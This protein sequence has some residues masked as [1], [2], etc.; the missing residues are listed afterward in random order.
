MS[1]RGEFL[2]A[3]FKILERHGVGY[4]VLRNYENLYEDESSDVD[5]AVQPEDV[6][7]LEV[8]L[9]EAGDASGHRL[10][11]RARFINYSHVYWNSDGGF[12]RVDFDT[13]FRWRIFPVLTAKSVITLRRREGEFYVPHPRHESVILLLAATERA[14]LSER[15]RAKL[16]RLYD[17]L[18]SPEELTRTFCSAFGLAG[19]DLALCQEEAANPVREVQNEIVSGSGSAL[20]RRGRTSL[21]RDSFR[22]RPS[23]RLLWKYLRGDVRRLWERMKSPVGLS[24]LYASAAPNQKGFE[25]FLEGT[26]VLFPPSKRVQ[27]CGARGKAL[28]RLRVLFKGG[29]FVRTVRVEK[30]TDLKNAVCARARFLFPSRELIWVQASN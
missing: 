20:W 24:I 9:A 19:S 25:E 10:V 14:E 7:G 21:V 26:E 17:Q 12:L 3:L 13:E 18:A 11:Q 8:S 22:D 29:L 23:R 1:P 27:M 2:S 5:L 28:Q 15:Y 30:D 6:P 4:C 16:G